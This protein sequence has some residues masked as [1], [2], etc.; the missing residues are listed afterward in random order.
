[1]VLRQLLAATQLLCL[2]CVAAEARKG[3]R[4]GA[5]AKSDAEQLVF[6]KASL[7]ELTNA[8]LGKRLGDV[9][10]PEK[11]IIF[12]T[13]SAFLPPLLNMT[14]NWFTHVHKCV[15]SRSA[16]PGPAFS[17]YSP[18]RR[19]C[20]AVRCVKLS[21]C[22]PQRPCGSAKAEALDDAAVAHFCF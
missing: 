10:S 21:P 5:T 19:A 13:T 7:L 2:A 20:A 1:M 14:R 8:T 17:S 18:H 16:S 9:A 15:R 3:L 4:D 11:C 22:C 12:T 6:K